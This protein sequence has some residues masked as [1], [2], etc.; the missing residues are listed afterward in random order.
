MVTDIGPQGR[1]S[2]AFVR[3]R[4]GVM[5]LA[6]GTKRRIPVADAADMVN[7]DPS[8]WGVQVHV[9]RR[10]VMQAQQALEWARHGWSAQQARPW[11]EIGLPDL[12]LAQRWMA[13]GARPHDVAVV[14]DAEEWLFVAEGGLPVRP[15]WARLRRVCTPWFAKAGHEQGQDPE[16]IRALAEALDREMEP[17]PRMNLARDGM[18]VSLPWT[19]WQNHLFTRFATEMLSGLGW[20]DVATCLRAQMDPDEAV[21]HVRSGAEMGPVRLLVALSR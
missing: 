2:T 7:A 11:A 6:P 16:A 14:G 15:E 9:P 4:A 1:P 12:H 8:G 10:V 5:M 3:L 18:V 19:Q 13:L 20:A 21:E 17:G